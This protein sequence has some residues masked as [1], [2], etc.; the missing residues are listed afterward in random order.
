[1]REHNAA[2]P[3]LNPRADHGIRADVNFRAKA[4]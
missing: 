3:Q 2:R 4:R 1:V